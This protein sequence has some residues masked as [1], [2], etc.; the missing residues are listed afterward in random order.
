M[1]TFQGRVDGGLLGWEEEEQKEKIEEGGEKEAARPQRKEEEKR[2]E[3]VIAQESEEEL[4]LFLGTAVAVVGSMQQFERGERERESRTK[5]SLYK[6]SYP[7]LY[8]S[9]PK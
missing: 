7:C 4:E 1:H 8:A 9:A 3:G 6:S 2:V 5:N